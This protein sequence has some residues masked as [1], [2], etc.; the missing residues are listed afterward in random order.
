MHPNQNPKLDDP[1]LL[2]SLEAKVAILKADLAAAAVEFPAITMAN[3]L[4]AEDMVLT[5]VIATN[6]LAIEIFSLDTG[7]LPLETYDLMAKVQAHYGLKLKFYYPNH[8]AVE[9]F[10][11]ENGINGFYDSVALRKACCHARKVEPLGRALAGKQ[12]WITGLRAEQSTTRTDLP[13]QQFDEGNGL[14]KLN[15]LSAWSEKEVW[16]YIRLNKVP[17]NALHDKFYPSI[18]CAPCTRP[19]SIGEDVRAGRWWWENPETKECGL[20]VKK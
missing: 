20:H 3:S 19:V 13:K 6:K 18:G 10:T 17:Y 12:A 2:A 4:G 8:E 9:A 1:V 5:D 7:R 16:A 15:P 11:R 14:I